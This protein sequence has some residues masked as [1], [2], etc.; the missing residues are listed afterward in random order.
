MKKYFIFLFYLLPF[1]IAQAAKMPLII[2][3]D[4]GTDD[5]IAILYLL[6]NPNVDIKAIMVDLNGASYPKTA[7]NHVALL[8]SMVN[9][10]QI[11]IYIGIQKAA[12]YN[13]TYPRY[14][15]DLIDK[16]FKN[17][18]TKPAHEITKQ[19]LLTLIKTQK[20]AVD[21]LALGSLTNIADLLAIQPDIKH[22]I[23]KLTIMGGAIDVPG[24]IN[25]FFP[26]T[27]NTFAEWNIYVDPK[28]F[29]DVLSAGIPMT[30]VSLDITNKTP[31]TMSF[32]QNLAQHSTTPSAK[33][34]YQ[35]L[36]EN[37]NYINAGEYD[38][39]DP[40]AAFVVVNPQPFYMQK[41]NVSLDHNNHYA[42]TYKDVNGYPVRLIKN[43]NQ[44][45]LEQTMIKTL[46]EN[47]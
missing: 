24:N 6:K 21:L 26:K 1:C 5:A 32:M 33:F 4:A 10:K 9:Q 38:F 35:M 28:A 18:H 20:Q 3:T 11:P 30:L 19:Q 43:I 27:K 37:I 23:A 31:V 39:W 2:D 34:V 16:S 14:A 45:Q 15:N 7:A 47:Y 12:S 17:N 13:N 41:I 29:Q 36:N 42:Q 46:N 44:Q 25:A 40:L 8:L 22:N